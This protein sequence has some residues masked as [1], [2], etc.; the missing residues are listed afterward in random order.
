MDGRTLPS[1]LTRA[2]VE[3]VHRAQRTLARS[4]LAAEADDARPKATRLAF[5]NR[6]FGHRDQEAGG[7]AA[8]YGHRRVASAT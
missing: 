7:H 2:H 8:T 4:R 5:R 1:L 3:D 6:A